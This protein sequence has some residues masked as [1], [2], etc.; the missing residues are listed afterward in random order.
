MS[1]DPGSL[2]KE[3]DA[4]WSALSQQQSAN[5]TL[6]ACSMTLVALTRAGADTQ[7]LGATLA[8]LTHAFPSRTIV[9]R[10]C[11]EGN[12]LEGRVSVQCWI[13]SGGR[14]QICSEQIEIDCPPDRMGDAGRAL[15][16]L[17]V[18]DLPVA[19]WAADASWLRLSGSGA[20]LHLASKV[21]VDGGAC[22]SPGRALE[23]LRALRSPDYALSDL[24]W[25][26]ITRW[27]Q[28]IYQ[29]LEARTP[30]RLDAV[31]IRSAGPEPTLT[32]R[33]LAAWLKTGLPVEPELT[34]VSDGEPGRI[35][36]VRLRGPGF[37]VL[38]DRPGRWVAPLDLNRLMHEELSVFG[39]DPVFGK[40]LDSLT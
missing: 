30:E 24:A 9:L 13:P 29:E 27:R 32:A 37:D 8:E 19:L 40:V 17:M 33:Y 28:A 39:N 20:V 23:H 16:G 11:P 31:S 26:R 18:P 14:Q 2:L 12:P 7:A 6:R 38:L 10:L 3:L 4:A 15:L 35:H 22:E 36:S 21:I 5:G 25:T 1:L 34:V